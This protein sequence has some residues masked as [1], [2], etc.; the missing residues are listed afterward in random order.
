MR[1]HIN[2][3]HVCTLRNARGT[4]Y[5][6]P[7]FAASI[8]E[9]AGADG[10]TLHLREDRRHIKDADAK[11]LRASIGTLMNLECAATDEMRSIVGELRPDVVTLVPERRE[12]RTT[13]GG[14]DVV[15]SVDKL[16]PFAELCRQL[17]I[18]L[19]LF[20]AADPAQIRASAELGAQQIELH[21]GEYCELPEARRGPE[22]ERLRAGARL[23]AEL[24]LD[25]AAGHGL[26]RHNVGPVAAI[27]EI[28]ELNIG[29]AVIADA[30]FMGLE[31]AVQELRAAIRRN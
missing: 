12:E 21:T 13:E 16:Q 28:Q 18:K 1:L 23:G 27:P 5:P 7:V 25:V 26:N 19:S 10:I 30:L 15:K 11:A 20:I 6:D 3:D 8:C 2:I 29:H 14:L 24:G 9:L 4:R 22:L 17:S 31:R